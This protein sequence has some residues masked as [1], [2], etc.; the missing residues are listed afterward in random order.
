MNLKVASL[1]SGCGGMDLGIQ[2][3]FEF[4][5]NTYT[6][7]PVELVFASD[8]DSYAVNIY[9]DNFKSIQR[10]SLEVEELSTKFNDELRLEKDWAYL[11]S[12]ATTINDLVDNE[13]IMKYYLDSPFYLNNLDTFRL[14]SLD[15]LTSSLITTR[16]KL[17]NSYIK[18]FQNLILANPNS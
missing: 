8:I 14:I 2:G 6:K 12:N 17:L 3:G 16:T 10:L 7:H 18:I 5:G 11:L 4:L 13:A 9:N 15:N 1:F